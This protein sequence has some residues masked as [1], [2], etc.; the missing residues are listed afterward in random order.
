MRTFILNF[1]REIVDNQNPTINL[2][3]L[4]QLNSVEKR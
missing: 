3:D 1:F 2:I 4:Y